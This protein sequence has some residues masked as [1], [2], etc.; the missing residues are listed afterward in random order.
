MRVFVLVTDMESVYRRKGIAS[1]F[2][3]S[4]LLI[5][6]S[7]RKDA[8]SCIYLKDNRTLISLYGSEI[9]QLRADEASAWGIIKKALKSRHRRPHTGVFIDRDV[10]LRDVVKKFKVDKVLA[11]SNVGIDVM[12]AFSS[13]RAFMYITGYLGSLEVD[14]M[15]VVFGESMRPE[16]EVVVV[17][18]ICDRSLR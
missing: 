15:Q 10:S 7:V 3:V 1:R 17:N 18:I 14:H 6:R 12:R 4:S 8:V 13:L 2:V 11:R 16:Q 5:S 9:R